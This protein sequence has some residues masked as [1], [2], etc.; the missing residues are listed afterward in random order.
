[1]GF[2]PEAPPKTAGSET[3]A[4]G[5]SGRIGGCGFLLGSVVKA[6]ADGVRTN[7]SGRADI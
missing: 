4:A 5:S 7:E 3:G 6:G 2:F 1:M